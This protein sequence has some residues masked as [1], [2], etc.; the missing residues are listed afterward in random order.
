MEPSHCMTELHPSQDIPIIVENL[1]HCKQGAL[2]K[3]VIQSTYCNFI[4]PVE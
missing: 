3:G 4:I 2:A 1:V